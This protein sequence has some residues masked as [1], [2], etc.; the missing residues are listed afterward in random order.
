M[1]ARHNDPSSV[2]IADF[3]FACK[4]DPQGCFNGMAGTPAYL[5]PEVVACIQR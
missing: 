5:A 2:K 1:L 4:L 3:G